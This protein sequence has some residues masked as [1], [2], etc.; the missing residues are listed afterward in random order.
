MITYPAAVTNDLKQTISDWFDNREVCDD[1]KFNAFFNRVLNRDLP[2][3]NQLLRIEPGV[4]QYDWLVQKYREAQLTKTETGTNSKT[5]S[6][7]RDIS[8]TQS[9]TK[10]NTR[11]FNTTD[12][13]DRD[14]TGSETHGGTYSRNKGYGKTSTNSGTIGNSGTRVETGSVSDS[15]TNSSSNDH[16]ALGKAAPQSV[17]YANQSGMPSTLDWSYP[18]SQGEDTN[19]ASGSS[20]NTTTFNNHTFTDNNTTTDARK[21][22]LGGTDTETDT[23]A[24]TVTKA[25]TDDG[26]VTHTGTIT[27]SGSNSLSKTVSDDTSTSLTETGS[28]SGTDRTQETGRDVDIATLLSNAKGFIM[29]TNAWEWL[30]NQLEVCFMGIYD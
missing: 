13:T 22:T 19:S 4:S 28:K 3:Y 21:T 18:G 9:G 25:G 7:E 29:G 20:S 17:S 11:T 23:D 5:G 8:D 12:T 27:D 6:V 1:D 2:R 30:S 14:V 24:R 15:G 26:T 10:G 16:K